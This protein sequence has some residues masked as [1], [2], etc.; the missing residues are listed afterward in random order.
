VKVANEFQKG[1]LAIILAS[2]PLLPLRLDCLVL[3][4]L[5]L[6]FDLDL[7]P[8][9]LPEHVNDILTLDACLE[10]LLWRIEVHEPLEA[11][12]G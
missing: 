6:P 3:T 9:E 2:S 10:L 5:L 8:A 4:L 1:P 12:R 11:D 7:A